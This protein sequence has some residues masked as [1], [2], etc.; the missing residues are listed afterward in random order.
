[1]PRHVGSFNPAT[2][3][4][5]DIAIGAGSACS[6]VVIANDSPYGLLFEGA[7]GDQ[8]L[9]QPYTTDRIKLRQPVGRLSWRHLYAMPLPN[10]PTSVVNVV[11]Y[12]QNEE[13][14]GNFPFAVMRQTNI[15]NP[16]PLE[17][18][19][20]TQTGTAFPKLSEQK[21]GTLFY[22][23]THRQL[24]FADR[25]YGYWLSV[26]AQHL[27]LHNAAQE[28]VNTATTIGRH[29]YSTRGGVFI[30]RARV[31]IFPD[32]LSEDAANYWS[33]RCLYARADGTFVTLG[34]HP[35]FNTSADLR[36]WRYEEFGVLE[37]VFVNNNSP[38]FHYTL[39]PTGTPASSLFIH[40]DLIV[41]DAVLGA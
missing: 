34:D 27:D 15:S 2:A 14:T 32:T 20:A 9:V 41:R 18:Q 33:V 29:L 21:P 5:G 8:G 31:A 7:I 16:V 24:Y 4:S 39:V 28:P 37:S 36:K 17:V 12:D 1:M 35:I 19:V 26:H 38:L 10:A 23:E 22:H 3:T 40:A 25:Q 6:N 13:I 30:E 11:L